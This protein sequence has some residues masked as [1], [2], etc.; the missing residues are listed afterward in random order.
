M[1]MSRLSRDQILRSERGKGI[2]IFPVQLA[3]SRIDNI[4]RLI[5]TLAIC[6][7]MHIYTGGLATSGPLRAF[8]KQVSLF[9]AFCVLF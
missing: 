3:T 5:H 9:V 7:T 2:L 8:G 1:E 4:T 6:V